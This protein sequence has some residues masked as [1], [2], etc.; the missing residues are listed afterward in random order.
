MG[1]AKET[2]ATHGD[3]WV[4][5]DGGAVH[6]SPAVLAGLEPVLAFEGEETL[7]RTGTSSGSRS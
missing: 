7:I 4:V 5:V 6:D 2:G 3:V 1:I